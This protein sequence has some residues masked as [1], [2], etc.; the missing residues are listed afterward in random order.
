MKT[1][2]YVI[3]LTSEHERRKNISDQLK[4]FNLD[5]SFYDAID[6]RFT[7]EST[8][9][10]YVINDT[11]YNKPSRPL[12]K[13]EIGCTLSH[14]KLISSLKHISSSSNF[15]ILEDDAIIDKDLA[16]FI[17]SKKLNEFDWDLI[18]LGYSKL[19]KD[20]FKKFYFKEPINTIQ[21][22]NNI[23][24]GN[25]WKDW[26]CGTVGYIINHKSINKFDS[27]TV[28]SMAD[29][30][31]Y[32]KEKLNLKIFHSRPLLICED[33][34]TFASSIEGERKEF[35]KKENIILEPIRLMR[36]LYRKLFFIAKIPK[37]R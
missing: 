10:S 33:F 30:W 25:V 15:L 31:H 29:D 9:N 27:L 19:K 21:Q 2:I 22:I 23:K 28:S 13:G 36:G 26:T 18:I 6:F 32:I 8:V 34:S 7:D 3:S 14:L 1:L 16:K 11:E 5:F 20:E 17:S 37:K 12:T 35:L 4:K 24:I